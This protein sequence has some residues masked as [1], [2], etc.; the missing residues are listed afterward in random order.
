MAFALDTDS[1]L[2]AFNRMVS[3]NPE[4]VVSDNGENF[5]AADKELQG[6]STED[7]MIAIRLSD[8]YSNSSEAKRL[9]GA[10]RIVRIMRLF[11]LNDHS[12][13]SIIRIV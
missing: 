1:L 8:H 12:N 6:V 10:I 9:F 7:R 5:V 11:G 13:R 2:N 3:G 4:E